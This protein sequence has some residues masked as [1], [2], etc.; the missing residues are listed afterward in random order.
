MKLTI[1]KAKEIIKE[2]KESLFIFNGVHPNAKA[3]F[4]A[5]GFIDGWN[6]AIETIEKGIV[7]SQNKLSVDR[8]S[9]LIFVRNLKV[10]SEG[11]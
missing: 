9:V 6:Q 8:E 3:Y 4:L 5:E 1:D 2:Y 10:N 7:E 11:K